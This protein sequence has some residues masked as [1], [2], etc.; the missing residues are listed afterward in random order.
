MASA[1]YNPA[2][3]HPIDRG[4]GSVRSENVIG[5]SR[6]TQRSA[7]HQADKPAGI[8]SSTA[9]RLLRGLLDFGRGEIALVRGDRPAVAERIL[10][11]AVTIAPEH[12]LRRHLHSSAGFDGF[13][14]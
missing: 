11:Q 12:V 10:E 2:S 8:A 6:P 4:T 5:P 9:A 1:A 14:E 7:L 13:S 3:A